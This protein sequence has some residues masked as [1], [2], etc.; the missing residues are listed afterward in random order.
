MVGFLS[1]VHSDHLQ[2]LESWG[3]IPLYCSPTTRQVGNI[4]KESSPIALSNDVAASTFR[5]VSASHELRK[6]DLG[7]KKATLQSP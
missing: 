3:R 6:W 5:N 1:H 4:Y 2:G 7:V